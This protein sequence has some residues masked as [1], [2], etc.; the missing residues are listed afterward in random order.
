MS[1]ENQVV[2]E[3]EVDANEKKNRSFKVKLSEEGQSYGRYNGD[4]PYQAANKALS[5]IIRNKVKAEE[6]VE[7]KLT[8]WLI[9]S[10]KGSSKRVHQ[11]EGERIK[12]AEPVKYKVGE[13]EIV[14]EY[15]NILKKIKK[16]DQVEVVTKKATKKATKKVAKKATKK[17]A[18]VATK[19]TKATTKATKATTK[20]TKATTKTTKATKATTKATKATKAVAT[21]KVAKAVATPKVAKATTKT[22][23]KA[24]ADNEV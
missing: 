6:A 24:K 21:P 7:G 18:K 3:V 5:E 20:T 13:N 23:K 17:V 4:S 11:Y 1:T 12:L 14:K 2:E 16:A 22:T 8:F 10:T 19:A 9:E 15:K